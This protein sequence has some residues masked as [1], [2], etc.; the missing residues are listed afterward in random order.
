M[1]VEQG[2]PEPTPPPQPP[3]TPARP[4]DSWAIFRHAFDEGADA[5]IACKWTGGRR[6]EVRTQN[7]SRLRLDLNK[8]PPDAPQQGPWI[9]QIDGQGIDITGRRG[10]VLDLVRSPNGIWSVDK[11]NDPPGT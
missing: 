5:D 3:R 11:E 2:K 6:L 4:K 1:A 10:K 8:L 7:V 9:L